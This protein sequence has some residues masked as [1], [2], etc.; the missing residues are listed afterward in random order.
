MRWA[1]TTSKDGRVYD[2]YVCQD[3]HEKLVDRAS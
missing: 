3:G 1:G 2:V